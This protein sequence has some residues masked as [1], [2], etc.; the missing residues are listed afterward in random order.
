MDIRTGPERAVVSA[1]LLD[2]RVD[3]PHVAGHSAEQ[4]RAVIRGPAPMRV[5]PWRWLE[6]GHRHPDVF[7]GRHWEWPQGASQQR[8]TI[9]V[10]VPVEQPRITGG[11]G[12]C[13]STSVWN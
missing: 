4:V 1:L 5:M 10:D 8:R 7:S 3:A 2:G 11:G 13:S 12:R 6:D 9:H